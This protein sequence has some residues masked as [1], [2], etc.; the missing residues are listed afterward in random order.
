M[1]RSVINQT[2]CTRKYILKSKDTHPFDPSHNEILLLYEFSVYDCHCRLTHYALD[3]YFQD[4]FKEAEPRRQIQ[5][6]NTNS[7]TINQLN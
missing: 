4:K 2:F 6:E 7:L 1:S 3:T 5:V